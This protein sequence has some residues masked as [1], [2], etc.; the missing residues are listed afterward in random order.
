[1][2]QPRFFLLFAVLSAVVLSFLLF[3]QAEPAI[4]A[5]AQDDDVLTSVPVDAAPTLDGMADEAFWEEAVPL[6]VGVR[7][8]A[9]N[10]D[11]I[12]FLKSV[13]TDDMVYFLVT[14][15]DPTQSFLRFPWEMQD[16]GTWLQLRDPGNVGGD[17]NVWYEDKFAFIW[18]INEIEFWADEGCFAACHRAG[19]D[20]DES[21]KPYGNKFTENEDGLGDIWHWKSV[22]NLNQLHDQYLDGTRWSEDTPSAGRHSDPADSGGYSNN[23]DNTDSNA[24]V[25]AFMPPG[26]DFARDG[27]PGYIL[28]SEAVPFDA[29]LF[30][31]G[32]R[33]PGIV[34]SEFEGD[35]GDI[36]AGWMWA[37][38]VW[39]L[40]LG[41]ALVTGSEFD[42]Q[43]EDLSATYLFGVAPFDNAQV[44]HSFH[45]GV[46]SFMFAQ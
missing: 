24:V 28:A 19:D 42:V 22:R 26:D 29:S 44:R 9:N 39:T 27:S 15:E 30:E 2:K 6:E 37:D 16:D 4:V 31:P 5:Y 41:R 40:E 1:M 25:P 14:W 36:A 23:V 7:R 33:I 21:G 34:I 43:F 18:E 11:T 45:N 46:L 3:P 17:E 10:S 32:D 20:N 38:G 12:V 8:G 35:G 13:Y